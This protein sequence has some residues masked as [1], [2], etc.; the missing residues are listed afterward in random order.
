MFSLAIPGLLMFLQTIVSD[1]L[2]AFV[3]I[4]ILVVV[5]GIFDLLLILFHF[6]WI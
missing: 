3:A 6:F 1:F 5:L 4:D 2:T